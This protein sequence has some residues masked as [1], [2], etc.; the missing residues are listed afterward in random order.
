MLNNPTSLSSRNKTIASLTLGIISLLPG[1]IFFSAFLRIRHEHTAS[2]WNDFVRSFI[3][4]IS[5]Y[6]LF[7]IDS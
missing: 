3:E 1:I 5:I 4:K 7:P 2:S 6:F